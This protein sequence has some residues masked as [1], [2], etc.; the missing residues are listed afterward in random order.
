MIS[1][2][3]RV[4]EVHG[5]AERAAHS[6]FARQMFAA[7][8]HDVPMLLARMDALGPV[9]LRE[10]GEGLDR[11]L[12]GLIRAC[13]AEQRTLNG[14]RAPTALTLRLALDRLAGVTLA[15]E[16]DVARCALAL[17][18][19]DARLTTLDFA[20]AALA[21][22]VYPIRTANGLPTAAYITG[23]LATLS[24]GDCRKVADGVRVTMRDGVLAAQRIQQGLHGTCGHGLQDLSGAI[25]QT[26][27]LIA[28][29]RQRQESHAKV[30]CQADQARVH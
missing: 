3:D 14:W 18:R 4:K 28:W 23:P 11:G 1:F 12:D 29:L 7:L 20:L 27:T 9:E 26:R 16:A 17:R 19:A 21:P 5:W 6:Q 15:L 24:T 25:E 8:S 30:L 10:V 13:V 2:K 22:Q